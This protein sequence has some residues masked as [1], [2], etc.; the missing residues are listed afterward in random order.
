MRK[1]HKKAIL[2]LSLIIISGVGI[3]P[4]IF[5]QNA[6]QDL[7]L[8]RKKLL[9][10]IANTQKIL[11]QAQDQTK[12]SLSYLSALR[13]Q[14]RNRRRLVQSIGQEIKQI[15]RQI[16]KRT[17]RID[18]LQSDISNL[19]SYAAELV[20]NGYRMSNNQTRLNFIFSSANFNQMLKRQ[21]YLKRMMEYLKDQLKLIEAAEEEERTL[22]QKLIDNRNEKLML[23]KQR[24]DEENVM[25]MD[26]LEMEKLVKA[27]KGKEEEIKQ[28]LIK[29][30]KAE[31]ELEAA[32]RKAIEEEI[33]KA[34]E[35]EER[36]R[37]ELARKKKRKREETLLPGPDVQLSK[38]FR[39]NYGRLP[40]PIGNG[41]ISEQFGTHAHPQLSNIQT[42]N[43]GINITSTKGATATAVFEGVVSAIVEVPGMQ[44]TVLVKH[45]E[46]FTVYSNLIVVEVNKG[47]EVAIGQ[48]IGVVNT[49]IQ[50]IT[51]LHFEVWKGSTKQNPERWLAKGI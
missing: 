30:Q 7:E 2:F 36:R 35:E 29:K 34:K 39:S 48:T 47:D 10:D 11:K 12:E 51:E 27:L 9:A 16:K 18:T 22:V 38:E 5:A 21:Q 20:Y 43:N 13:N 45:G 17:N 33:R 44:L 40:W 26:E 1:V 8:K 37:Q 23:L 6:K 42:E 25:A 31:K 41:Y 28:D 3:I 4:S 46:Y 24:K 19:K 50:G 32:I 49:T 15:D 14:V